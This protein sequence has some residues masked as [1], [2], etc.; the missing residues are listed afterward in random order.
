M[1]ELLALLRPRFHGTLIAN[2]GLTP[3]TGEVLIAGGEADMVAFGRQYVANPDL[4]ARI[5]VGGPFN[6]PD[7]FTF[8][9]G[10]EKGYTDYPAL[11]AA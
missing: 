6:E 3:E 5:A 11:A 9:G 10:S 1:P 7:P 8:Y 2:A 4:V